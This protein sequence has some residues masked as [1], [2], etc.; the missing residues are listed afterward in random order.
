MTSFISLGRVAGTPPSP[1]TVRRIPWGTATEPP[2]APGLTALTCAALF[3]RDAYRVGHRSTAVSLPTGTT[4]RLLDQ[5]LSS[6]HLDT[7]RRALVTQRA[8]QMSDRGRLL[9][10]ALHL[11]AWGEACVAALPTAAAATAITDQQI[12]DCARDVMGFLR[13]DAGQNSYPDPLPWRG[14]LYYGAR[15]QHRLAIGVQIP[16]PDGRDGADSAPLAAA[17]LGRVG[18]P[19]VLV[20]M[21]AGRQI[22]YYA[23]AAMPLQEH[24]VACLSIGLSTVA[25]HVVALVDTVRHVMRGIHDAGIPEAQLPYLRQSVAL[26]AAIHSSPDPPPPPPGDSVA[27]ADRG[28]PAVAVVGHLPESTL[29]QLR[30]AVHGW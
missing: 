14:G 2:D 27:L 15:N 24:G 26:H 25:A 7:L 13:T 5:R 21:L 19:G 3:G 23:A 12:I 9:Q 28:V 16:W 18:T 8:Q 6:A 11:A 30:E 22:P 29:T 1:R 4:P 17:H 20:Q 10:R